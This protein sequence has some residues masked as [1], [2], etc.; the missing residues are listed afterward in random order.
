[1]TKQKPPD[2]S[3]LDEYSYPLAEQ[4]LE[5]EQRLAEQRHAERIRRAAQHAREREPI[6]SREQLSQS[7]AELAD[8]WG[9][10]RKKS[11]R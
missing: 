5:R 8:A 11:K 1:M 6:E 7:V 10:K 4:R 3:L 2:L 9:L